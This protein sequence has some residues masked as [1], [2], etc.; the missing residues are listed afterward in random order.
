MACDG[1]PKPEGSG[2]RLAFREHIDPNKPGL[3]FVIGIDGAT[4]GQPFAE[5]AANVTLNDQT[6]GRFY[7]T[8]GQEQCWAS[9]TELVELRG[10]TEPTWRIN[11]ILY[12][13]G[14]LPAATGTGSVTLVELEFSGQVR[15]EVD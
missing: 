10:T 11:G 5:L 3:S 6:G 12:C 1:M 2:I 7:G 4:L 14:A 9:T 15:A 13:A 8:Q